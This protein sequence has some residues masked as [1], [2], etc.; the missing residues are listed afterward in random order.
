MYRELFDLNLQKEMTSFFLNH[1]SKLGTHRFYKKNE[2]INPHHADEIC[3]V[4]EGTL[5]QILYNIDGNEICFFR[6]PKG[7]IYG[8]M[9]YFDGYR[10][11]VIT[12]ALHNS[13]VS[14]IHRN[15][16]EKE[17]E[18]NPRI[19]RYFIHSIT[20]KYRLVM[21]KMADD[22]FND[23]V[24]KIAS[25]LLRFAAM[26]EGNLKNNIIIEYEYTYTHQEL[27][28]YLGCSR[29]TVTNVLNFFRENDLI[30]IQNKHIVI[31][32]IEGLKQYIKS[33]W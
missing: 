24:G 11:C 25:T 28:K 10:T 4:I 26:Q 5:K 13:T 1:L 17:L 6:L 12:K 30:G 3:I 2:E 19:Y 27:A 8:E 31:K 15:V 7:T 14:A 23:S 18:K 29:I 32:N 21:L 16:L 22:K 9:D 20:R 33:I